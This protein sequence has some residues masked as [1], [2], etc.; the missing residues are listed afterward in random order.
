MAQTAAPVLRVDFASDNVA[1][2]CPEAQTTL[3]EELARS[4]P[5]YGNDPTTAR[6][7]H[8]LRDLFETDCAVYFVFAGTAANALALAAM[9][10]PYTSVIAHRF[11][12]VETDEC[13]APEF[14][15]QGLKLR[16][17]D[18]PRAKLDLDATARLL[19]QPRFVHH[20]PVSAVSITQT[21]ELGGLYDAQEIRALCDLAHAAGATVHMDGARFANAV[22]ELGVA[23]AE[24]TWRAG[25]DILCFGGTK[26]G[27]P[28][29]EAILIFNPELVPGFDYRIK[30]AGQLASKQRYLSAPW[31]GMLEDGAWL[32]HARHANAC[33]QELARRLDALPGVTVLRPVHGNAIFVEIPPVAAQAM[34]ARGWAFYLF[35]DRHYR[36]MCSWATQPAQI[37]AFVH[38]LAALLDQA[39]TAR[40]D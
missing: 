40:R 12:H 27:M 20:S 21:T 13:N 36:L 14:F 5:P 16:L 8:L 17:V 25:V 10:K 7:V 28:A 2:V 23:P 3:I 38:E 6:A 31:V 29:G 11:S 39:P 37:D 24:L 35:T 9:R 26:Q 30:Q 19:H 33:A 22:A 1:G 15:A 32:R 34:Q 4:A 18:G